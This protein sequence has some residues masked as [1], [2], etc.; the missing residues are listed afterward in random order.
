VDELPGFDWPSQRRVPASL[1]VAFGVKAQTA[2]GTEV[3]VAEM[4][5]FRPDQPQPDIWYSSFGDSAPSFAF[6]RFDREA[7]LVPGPWAFEAWDGGERL[8]RVEFEV[9]P[10]DQAIGIVSA[11]DG[12]S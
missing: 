11:C 9:V 3:P 7:E 2:P 1:G 5:V 12:V 6:F 10:A 8:Y 4:R